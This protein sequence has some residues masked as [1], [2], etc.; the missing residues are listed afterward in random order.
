M[1]ATLLSLSTIESALARCLV[2]A[3]WQD[4]LLGLTAALVLAMTRDAARPRG[5]PSGSAFWWRWL[6]CPHG[7][8]RVSSPVWA[9]P[10]PA[11]SA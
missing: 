4:A 5:M 8:S 2:Q 3:L 7:N 10:L 11:C 6:S 9:H 1:S